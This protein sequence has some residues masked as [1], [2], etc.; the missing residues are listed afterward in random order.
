MAAT[1]IAAAAGGS[2]NSFFDTGGSMYLGALGDVELDD[3]AEASPLRVSDLAPSSPL[4][5]ATTTPEPDST[6][7]PV[8]RERID[9]LRA[10]VKQMGYT[11]SRV[12][13][14]GVVD[15]DYGSDDAAADSRASARVDAEDERTFEE[16]IS[17]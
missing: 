14:S 3:G 6:P 13:Q 5:P 1:A 7:L 15:E 17:R 8:L 4:P 12:E 16:H 11:P 2:T 10:G 9:N